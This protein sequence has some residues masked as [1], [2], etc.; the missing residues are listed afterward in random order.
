MERKFTLTIEGA[1]RT[2]IKKTDD[3][4]RAGWATDIY[5][6]GERTQTLTG[7]LLGLDATTNRA[8]FTAIIE[9]LSTTPANSSVEVK[10]DSQYAINSMTL[11]LD[12][13]KVK[14]WKNSR[15]KPV[16]NKD[17]IQ[18]LDQL[19]NERTVTYSKVEFDATDE[20]CDRLNALAR[21]AQ[22]QQ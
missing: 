9:G 20:A 2:N 22:Y 11:W 12:N 16:E 13:W 14:G 10:T 17:L 4:S 19:C 21:A 1:S 6:N 3:N 8:V 5:V 7:G 15:K 18:K